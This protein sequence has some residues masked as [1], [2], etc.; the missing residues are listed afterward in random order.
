MKAYQLLAA[1]VLCLA[2]CSKPQEEWTVPEKG[3]FRGTVTVIYQNAPFN[4]ENISVGFEPSEDGKTAILTIYKIKFVPQMPVTID[5]TIPNIEMS[6][7]KSGAVLACENVIPLA[8]GGEYPR[9]KVTNFS[10]IL[11]GDKLNFNLN[12]GDTPTSFIGDRL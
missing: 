6:L 7:T 11:I 4:N 3:D 5:V 12:F 8:L 2:A 10:G 1:V 9:Y